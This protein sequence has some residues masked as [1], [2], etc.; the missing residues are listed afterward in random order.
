MKKVKFFDVKNDVFFASK[1]GEFL[2]RKKRNF[3]SEKW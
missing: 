2:G 3:S 1:N